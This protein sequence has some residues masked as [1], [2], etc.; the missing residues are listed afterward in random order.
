MSEEARNLDHGRPGIDQL[1]REVVS[2]VV[3]GGPDRHPDRRSWRDGSDGVEEGG[4]EPRTV[5][6]A[7]PLP[8]GSGGP[9]WSVP[10]GPVCHALHR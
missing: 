8:D 10:P 2:Q 9:G 3:P 7:E 1:T 4:G 5:R 6:D